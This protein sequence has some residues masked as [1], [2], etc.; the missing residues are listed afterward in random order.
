MRLKL[1]IR[2]ML[3][4]G[5]KTYAEVCLDEH[6][7]PYAIQTGYSVNVALIANTRRVTIRIAELSW[8]DIFLTR[9]KKW[10]MVKKNFPLG[11]RMNDKTHVFEGRIFMNRAGRRCYFM[12]ALSKT[13]SNNI[14]DMVMQKWGALHNVNGLETIEHLLFKKYAKLA[15]KERDD[16]GKLTKN[17]K[18][19]WV[20]FPQGPGFR[21]LHLEH[22]LPKRAHII[23]NRL[24]FRSAELARVWEASTPECA[25][26]LSPPK[27]KSIL[28][29]EVDCCSDNPWLEEF[30]RGRGVDDITLERMLPIHKIK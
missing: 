20:I 2:D 21:V 16:K 30:I 12:M 13:I 24:G 15:R 5:R 28:P 8:R 29:T 23:S 22:G 19:Q 27:S 9:R 3:T 4:L 7:M 17:P 6:F 25:V 10:L 18:P 14:C 11:I 1:A 26:I